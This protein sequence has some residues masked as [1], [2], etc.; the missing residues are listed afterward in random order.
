[1][2]DPSQS[3]L[4]DLAAAIRRRKVSSLEATKALL[5][6]IPKWQPKLNAFARL[7]AEDALKAA[8]AADRALAAGKAKGP[9][10]G[11]PLAHKDMYYVKGKLAECGSTI[12]K[13]WIATATATAVA[14]LEAAGALRLGAL[15]MVEFAFGPTGHNPHTGHVR[16]P[17]ILRASPAARRPD[18]ARRSRR[19]WCPPRSAR[20]PAARSACRRISAASPG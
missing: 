8:K 16:N 17:W 11:V 19:G 6:R 7:E 12:R 4:K 1:V 2:S 13:G 18:R 15:N 3:T 9:L 5:A 14:R 10:H 20:I